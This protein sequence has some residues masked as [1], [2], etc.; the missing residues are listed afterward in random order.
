MKHGFFAGVIIAVL[1]LGGCN[2]HFHDLIT[3]DDNKIL[4]FTVPG[5]T[6]PAVITKNS[7]SVTADKDTDIRSLVPKATVSRKAS[8]LPLTLEYIQSAFPSVNVFSRA[9]EMYTRD[10]FANHVFDL[11]KEDKNFNVPKLTVPIDFSEPVDFFVIS[12]K[13]NIRRYTVYV[14]KGINPVTITGLGAADKAYDGTTRATVTGTAVIEG[15][16]PGDTV[17]VNYGTAAFENAAVGNNKTVT[18]SGF[19][20]AGADA[21]NYT[22]SAQPAS[23]KAAILEQSDAIAFT[24]PEP[25][26]VKTYGDAAFTNAITDDHNGSGA[27]TYSSEY[28]TVA[29][30]DDEGTVTMHKAGTTTI[31]AHKAAAPGYAAATRSYNLTV[32]PKPVTISG[33]GAADKDFD[34]TTTAMVTGTAV[35]EG[36]MPGDMVTVDYGTAEFEDAVAGNNKTVTFSDFSLAGA[37]E[38]NYTLSAQPESVTAS[39]FEQSDPIAFADPS[40]NI[41]KTYGDAAFNNPI[42][43]DH[44]GTGAITYS[45]GNEPVAT[46]DNN[47]RVTMHKAGT[48]TITA[49]K[50]AD[51]GYAEAIRSYSLTVGPKPVTITGLG[52]A[53]KVY[54]R[55]TTATRTGTA[56]ISSY[57]INGDTVTV[58]NGTAAFAN[59]TVGNGKAVTFSGFSLGGANAGNYSLSAQPASATA[60]IT[61]KSV[62]IT[63]LGA[64]SK[65]YDGTTT[66]TITGTATISSYIITGD[67]VTVT[68]GTAA[69][70]NETV[71]N[72][73]T[74]TFSGFT[75]GGAAATNYSLSAQPASVTANITRIPTDVVR[76]TKGTFTMGSPVGEPGRNT[77]GGTETQ[78]TVNLTQDFSM[79]KYQITRAQYKMVMNTTSVLSPETANLPVSVNWYDAIVF[80]NKLSMLEGYTPAYRINNSTDPAAWGAVPTANNSPTKATWDAVVIVA[81]SQGYRLPTE[82]QWEYACRAGTQTAFNR[83]ATWSNDWG[84]IAVNSGNATHP[85]GVKTQN[86]WGLYDM[87][88]NVLEWCWDWYAA[89]S[90]T[91]VTDP[92]GPSSGTNRVLRGGAYSD[93]TDDSRSAFRGNNS[94]YTSRAVFGFR[95][96][97]P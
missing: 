27:I 12:G 61:A 66:A 37:D 14:T 52:A 48:A 26:I 38:G 77:T 6:K 85:V 15:L 2:N 32:E 29:T 1:V 8:L 56:T 46:V 88:G 20:L 71:G 54:D 74:V 30:V 83:G 95:I 75:L 69:F 3:P 90:A 81:G 19:S 58:T 63:G 34:G 33:L 40:P 67:T 18:F 28:E 55:T 91:T 97:R 59:A 17:T 13:G 64:A 70:A 94:P 76:V 21:G 24:D 10:D 96:S 41:V 79:G 53:D 65:Q 22:L 72:N 57:I 80:C 39:I 68:N 60:N 87:H 47:G 5:Q 93:T 84:W 43:A 11:I 7:V 25:H 89:G 51:A 9:A 78:H 62:T 92:T 35:I 31:T 82:A 36:L 86:T 44:N 45:S 4:S 42:T 49:R 16:M 73:K 50:A 23:V